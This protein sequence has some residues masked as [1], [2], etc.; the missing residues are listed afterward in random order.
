MANKRLIGYK[1]IRTEY[2]KVALDIAGLGN[3]SIF[4]NVDISSNSLA[5]EHLK[6]A[7]VLDIWFEPVYDVQLPMITGSTGNNYS[8]AVIKNYIKYGCAVLP[9]AWFEASA[10]RHIMELT[11]DSGVCINKGQINQIREYLLH[12]GHITK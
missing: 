4:E 8:G 5:M 6:V 1:L 9:V 7:G 12:H 3:F 2:K 11:L 10:N